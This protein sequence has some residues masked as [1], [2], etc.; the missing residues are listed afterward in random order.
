[1][2]EQD[3]QQSGVTV[4]TALGSFSV[5]G[6]HSGEIACMLSLIG[7]VLI[8]YMVWEHSRD[9]GE[10]SNTRTA[11]M[12]KLS[13]GLHDMAKAQRLMACLVSLPQERREEEF[14]SMTGLCKQVERMQ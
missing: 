2:S 1:M 6:A 7:V 13:A 8:G 10:R 14:R 12:E 11:Q 4:K 5:L 3:Q 9:V